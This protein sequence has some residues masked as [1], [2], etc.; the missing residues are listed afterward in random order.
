MALRRAG[1]SDGRA[2]DRKI[3]ERYVDGSELK[4]STSSS[5]AELDLKNV[6]TECES[7]EATNDL[8]REDEEPR[9]ERQ[10]QAKIGDDPDPIRQNRILSPEVPRP[11]G[12]FEESTHLRG[13][14]S[15][16]G[17]PEGA[18]VRYAPCLEERSE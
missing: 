2:S 11:R 10:S 15:G 7:D 8:P 3:G 14:L 17:A 18:T 16:E 5:R 12:S 1:A 6:K 9:R 4:L 13:R